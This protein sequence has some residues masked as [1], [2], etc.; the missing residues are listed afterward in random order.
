M[1]LIVYENLNYLENEYDD[2][3]K[4]NYSKNLLFGKSS[5]KLKCFALL[6]L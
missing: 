6:F 2:S 4:V 3:Y 1:R 5:N